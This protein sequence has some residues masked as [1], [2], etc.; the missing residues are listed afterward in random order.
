[1]PTPATNARHV[2]PCCRV[3]AKSPVQVLALAYWS[4][5]YAKRIAET[6]FVHRCGSR[7]MLWGLNSHGPAWPRSGWDP[8]ADCHWPDS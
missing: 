6:F 7:W 1:M 5:H 4:F 8:E 2:P 3:P